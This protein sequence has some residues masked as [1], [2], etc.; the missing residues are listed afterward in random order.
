[1]LN[2]WISLLI[3]ASVSAISDDQT[4]VTY[5]SLETLERGVKIMK[6]RAFGEDLELKLEPA[7]DVISDDF[8]VVDGEGN[9]QDNDATFLKKRLFRDEEKGSALYIKEMGSMEID[10]MI[11]SELRIEPYKSQEEGR[12]EFN[13]HLVTKIL[14]EVRSFSDAVINVHLGGLLSERNDT[15]DECMEIEYLF[16]A[17][18]NF[19][20]RF[21]NSVQ[22]QA[23]LGT[24]F[25][26]VQILMDRLNLN[27]KTRLIGTILYKDN[28]SF[29]QISFIPGQDIIDANNI[30]KNMTNFLCA[31]EG[32]ELIKRA[33]VIIL[34]TT[35]PIRVSYP[36]WS[37]INSRL[38]GVSN[39]GG[40]CNLCKKFAV[41]RDSG[42]K[43][44]TAYVIAHETAHLI[45]SPHDGVGQMFS[46]PGSPGSL[47][48]PPFAG[49]IMGNNFGVTTSMFSQCS[50]ENIKYFLSKNEASCIKGCNSNSTML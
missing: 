23:Y 44:L 29:F 14:P 18:S 15:A 27:L 7:G 42:R 20:V 50:R 2:C 5:P 12:N 48:C 22:L 19:A 17:E 21:P 39:L 36:F 9:I 37:F 13:A 47:E 30:M 49:F 35:N 3:C 25:V 41:I 43:L 26:Q 8:T 4:E 46:L 40:A 45:G 16:M 33:D 32:N 6:I 31:N 28:P 1:M 38:L 10:G 34:I 24:L 11:N